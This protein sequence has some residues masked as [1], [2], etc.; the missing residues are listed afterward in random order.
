[1]SYKVSLEIDKNEEKAMRDVY[2]ETMLGMAEADDRIVYLDADLMN[3][4]GMR[5]FAA[6]YPERTVNCGIQEANMVGVAAGLSV[7]GK[8]PFLHTFGVFASRR[9][10]D[11]VFISAAFAQANIRII[12]SDPGVTA[13]YNGGT[14][15]P[16][17]DIGIMRG[18]PGVTVIEPTDS[19]MLADIVKQL[20]DAFGVYYIRLSRKNAVKVFEDNSTFEI[21][22]A[23]TIR[24]GKDVTIIAS[25]ICVADAR[26]AAEE[27]QK[28]S[29]SAQV[30]NMFTIKPVDK[31]AII[32][33]AQKT[34]C[35][36]TAENHNVINGL[37]SAV[38]EVLAENC[39]VPMERV[40]VM[41]EFG[42][43]GSVDYLKERFKLTAEEIARKARIAV[44]RKNREVD[45]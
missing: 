27:L 20:K 21:G 12:G 33:A 40:G 45:F 1:M 15:M 35:V 7:A 34:G 22:R 18:I 39:P 5:P 10:A 13:S 3:S 4:I 16:F 8:V 9:V 31:K 14:H 32:A 42:E 6:K 24:E 37:G 30:I 25:G 28:E 41:D 17:E 43:V 2:C 44:K 19:V 36:V 29:V 23:A 26:R 11:Q 38:A